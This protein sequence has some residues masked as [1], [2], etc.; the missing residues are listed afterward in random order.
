[1]TRSQ[2]IMN[3]K[4]KILFYG[5]SNTYGYDP[6]DWGD[7]RYPS[8]KRWTTIL[9]SLAGPDWI[10]VPEGMNGRTLPELRYDEKWLSPLLTGLGTDDIFAVMLGTNDLLQTPMPDA[11]AA[12]CRMKLFLEFLTSR[13]TGFG[14]WV[15]APPCAGSADI[16]DPLYRRYC[17]AGQEMNRGFRALAEE[18]RVLFTDASEWDISLTGDLVHFSET[19]HRQFAEHMAAVLQTF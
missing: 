13:T 1:M 16:R 11:E 14:I 19:G 15:I 4:R 2:M 12:V 18:Y 10:I 3:K 8:G 17:R 6:A 9:A 5:D 7:F